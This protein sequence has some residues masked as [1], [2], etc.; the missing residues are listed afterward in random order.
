MHIAMV[1]EVYGLI[2]GVD[3][4]GSMYYRNYPRSIYTQMTAFIVKQGF[5]YLCEKLPVVEV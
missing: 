1:K 4:Y 2:I 3:R 5:V